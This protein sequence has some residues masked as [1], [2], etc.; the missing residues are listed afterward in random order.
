[1]T[2]LYFLKN[3]LRL[4]ISFHDCSGIITQQNRDV[5]F[6]KSFFMHYSIYFSKQNKFSMYSEQVLFFFLFSEWTC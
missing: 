4:K 2:D 6:S 1:M 5:G 3:I